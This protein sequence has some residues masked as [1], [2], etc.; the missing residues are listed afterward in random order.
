MKTLEQMLNIDSKSLQGEPISVVAEYYVE[1]MLKYSKYMK[2]YSLTKEYYIYDKEQG[3]WVKLVSKEFEK[4]VQGL[5]RKT[6]IKINS[7]KYAKL[8]AEELS[9]TE[10][11]RLGLPVIES[12]YLCLE[13]VLLDVRTGEIKELTEEVF[14]T[15]KVQYK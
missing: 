8:V 13:N 5:I 2:Y 6:G 3:Y 9:G 7:S 12:R 1:I 14:V 11:R 10:I 4:E 15:S